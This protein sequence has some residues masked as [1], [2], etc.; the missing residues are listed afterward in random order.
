M[1][2]QP[3]GTS[4]VGRKKVVAGDPLGRHFFPHPTFPNLSRR[5]REAACPA[6]TVEFDQS[7]AIVSIMIKAATS[8]AIPTPCLRLYQ[9]HKNAWR[10]AVALSHISDTRIMWMTS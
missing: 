5:A 10:S 3:V 9:Q 8:H 7:T 2:L 1:L 4:Q 6:G